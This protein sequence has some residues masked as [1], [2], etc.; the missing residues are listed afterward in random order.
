MRQVELSQKKDWLFDWLMVGD[1][2]LHLPPF[3]KRVLSFSAVTNIILGREK[4]RHTS[5]CQL[6]C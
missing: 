6:I 1:N 5:A 3:K 2:I 4:I